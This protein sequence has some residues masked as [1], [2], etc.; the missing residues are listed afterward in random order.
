MVM[1][2]RICGPLVNFGHTFR[3]MAQADFTRRVFLRQRDFLHAEALLVNEILDRLNADGRLL[4]IHL[5]RVVEAASTLQTDLPATP[6][7]AQVTRILAA[8]KT[9][10][11]T[12]DQWKIETQQR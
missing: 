4:K 5:D 7:Q 3:R 8:A 1:V 10:R 12:L 6:A 2:H 11:A 9:C